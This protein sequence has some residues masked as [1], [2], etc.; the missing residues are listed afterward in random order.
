MNIKY[1]HPITI[2]FFVSQK[3]VYA[4][5]FSG[6]PGSNGIPGMPGIPGA[7]G[8]QGQQGKDGAKGEPGV[9]GPR[10]MT[11][12]R[13]QKGNP[14]SLGKNGAPGMMGIKG[15][16][17]D[18]GS[19]GSSGPPGIKGVKGEQGSKGE[20]GEI[21]NS[22]VSQTNWKQC[23]WKSGDGRDSGKIKVQ[24]CLENTMKNRV[25]VRANL[26]WPS[27]RLLRNAVEL[28]I[29]INNSVHSGRQEKYKVIIKLFPITLIFSH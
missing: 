21:V 2:C 19:R 11:G 24:K 3:F 12:T 17:G 5:G 15:N 22:A 13:G 23:V 6:I 9:K 27:L 1:V 8:P 26:S 10:G 25:S 20:K 14:G 28:K 16:K 29:S 18:E 4:H 7:P